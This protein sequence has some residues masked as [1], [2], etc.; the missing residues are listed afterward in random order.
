[1]HCIAING[2]ALA[3][4][5]FLAITT[6]AAY[7]SETPELWAEFAAKRYQMCADCAADVLL[8]GLVAGSYVSDVHADAHH[9][10]AA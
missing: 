10:E 6:L 4:D 3:K 8:V 9:G 1:M 2:G 7:A 5:D